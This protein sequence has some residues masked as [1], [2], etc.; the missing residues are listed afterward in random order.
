MTFA[1]ISFWFLA[2]LKKVGSFNSPILCNI[3]ITYHQLWWQFGS[4]TQFLC[5]F[6]YVCLQIFKSFQRV[7]KKGGNL[8][9]LRNWIVLFLQ[10]LLH[11][12]SH[13]IR[14]QLAAI[15]L[16][17]LTEVMQFWLSIKFYSSGIWTR[18]KPSMLQIRLPSSTQML[19]T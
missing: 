5:H 15:W 2:F 14:G 6:R 4:P 17:G 9:N 10:T 13:S 11:M 12:L 19:C 3:S 8:L 18:D 1:L 16:S 7:H